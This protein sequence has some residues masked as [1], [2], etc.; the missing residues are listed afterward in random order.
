MATAVFKTRFVKE[1]TLKDRDFEAFSEE[2][3]K[4]SEALNKLVNNPWLYLA[5][6]KITVETV[7][8]PDPNLNEE[9]WINVATGKWNG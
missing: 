6:L 1:I 4:A 3:T 7:I 5:S 2:S 9:F 8:E